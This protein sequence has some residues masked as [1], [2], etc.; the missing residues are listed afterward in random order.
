MRL[1]LGTLSF[2]QITFLVRTTGLCPLAEFITSRLRWFFL[3]VTNI[4]FWA[5][6]C[7]EWVLESLELVAQLCNCPWETSTI[8]ENQYLKWSLANVK[9]PVCITVVSFDPFRIGSWC[10]TSLNATDPLLA[11]AITWASRYVVESIN[12]WDFESGSSIWL[13]SH[14]KQSKIVFQI[15]YVSSPLLAYFNYQFISPYLLYDCCQI[16]IQNFRS[17]PWKVCWYSYPSV[18]S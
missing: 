10:N 5:K 18:S 17:F 8:E 12:S 7:E 9:Q 11:I 15:P 1:F 16:M 3:R 6:I 13:L 2:S 14:S 4:S